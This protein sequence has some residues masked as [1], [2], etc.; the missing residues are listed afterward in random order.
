MDCL[1]FWNSKKILPQEKKE[2]NCPKCHRNDNDFH[3]IINNK[4]DDDGL[5]SQ[6]FDQSFLQL[7]ASE[8][9]LSLNVFYVFKELPSLTH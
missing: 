5:F 9:Y 8:C 6:Y 2:L 3:K 1:K 7:S 4:V